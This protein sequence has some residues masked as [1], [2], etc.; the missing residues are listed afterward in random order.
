RP[1]VCSHAGCESRFARNH[2]LRRHERIHT[3]E[4]NWHCHECGRSFGRRDALARH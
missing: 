1:F 2:D 4:K 3:G